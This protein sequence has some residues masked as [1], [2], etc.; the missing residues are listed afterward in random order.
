M[1]QVQ[2]IRREYNNNASK[3]DPP[4]ASLIS[5]LCRVAICGWRGGR[6]GQTFSLIRDSMGWRCPGD[7]DAP[8]VRQPLGLQSPFSTPVTLDSPPGPLKTAIAPPLP[9]AR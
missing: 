7:S 8:E 9:Q 6:R 2:L 4:C 1:L 5:G 3:S